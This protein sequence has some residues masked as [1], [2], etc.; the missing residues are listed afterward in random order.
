MTKKKKPFS[1][2]PIIGTIP[3]PLDGKQTVQPVIQTESKQV[4]QVAPLNETTEI[5]NGTTSSAW[6][7]TDTSAWAAAGTLEATRTL[8]DKCRLICLNASMI[9]R[10]GTFNYG[11]IYVEITD[12]LGIIIAKFEKVIENTT[13]GGTLLICPN[14]YM[15]LPAGAIV[16]MYIRK[17]TT[18]C[19]ASG[20]LSLNIQLLK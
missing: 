8:N 7:V 18:A 5:S 10:A 11:A 9:V 16:N 19:T 2:F 13:L 17:D 1:I 4:L 3:I 6:F 15:I 14:Q 12:S 20:I